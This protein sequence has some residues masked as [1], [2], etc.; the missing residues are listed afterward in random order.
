MGR[1]KNVTG[2]Y[3][4]TDRATDYTGELVDPFTGEI[5]RPPA[6]TKQEFR[7]ECDI[8]NIIKEY[9]VTGQIQHISARAAAGAYLDLPSSVDL[10]ESLHIQMAATAA[11]AGLP[12]RVRDRFANDPGQFLAFF[13]NPDNRAE[14]AALGLLATPPT[15]PEPEGPPAPPPAEPA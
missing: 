7:D 12:S 2:F 6:M 1:P 10:Q 4:E 3:I 9:L 8:N 15:P 11:F 14:A 5:Y 13:E